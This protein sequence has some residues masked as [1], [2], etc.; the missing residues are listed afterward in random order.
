MRH[1]RTA[2]AVLGSTA[3]LALAAPAAQAKTVE[4]AWVS[5]AQAAPGQPVTVSVTCKDKSAKTVTATSKAFTGG[6]VTLNAG[7]DGKYSGTITLVSATELTLTAEQSAK[8]SDWGVDGKCPNGDEFSGSVGLMPASAGGGTEDDHGATEP[9]GSV[10]TGVGGSVT[11]AGPTQLAAGGALVAAG[12]GGFWL[13]R[14]R[15]DGDPQ[16]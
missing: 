3:L 4:P 7:S 9:H 16:D 2:A 8:S 14:R 6:S 12:L 1:P 15:P 11:G 10:Q 5:P 13:L